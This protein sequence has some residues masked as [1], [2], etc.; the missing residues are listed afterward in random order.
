MRMV[1]VF[2]DPSYEA[3][4]NPIM[5]FRPSRYIQDGV[6]PVGEYV[7]VCKQYI[8]YSDLDYSPND[9]AQKIID[10]SNRTWAGIEERNIKVIPRVVI[11]Y[12][13]GP[14][15]G[16]AGYWP[17][18]VPHGDP[19]EQWKGEAFK[20]RITAFIKNLGAAWDNDPRVA[21]IEAGIWGNWGEHHIYPLKFP[22]GSDR[23]PLDFQKA[24]GDAFIQAFPNKKVMIRYPETFTAYDFGYYWDSFALPED[25]G[26]GEAI[27]MK[28]NWRRQMISGEV[29]YD[30]GDQSVVGGS[31][32]GTLS[33]TLATDHI[34]NWVKL[35]HASS[36]GWISDY[37]EK[38]PTV[39]ANASKMQKVLGYRFVVQRASYNQTVKPGAKLSL[40]FDVSNNGSAPFYYQWPVELSLLD[41]QRNPVWKETVHVDIRN[42]RP[43]HTYK[44]RDEFRIPVKLPVGTYTLA[45]AV[46]DPAGN[47]P[48]L[49]FANVNYYNGGRMP[50]GTIGIGRLPD[51]NDLDFFDSL[52]RD[53]SLHYK[54]GPVSSPV[55][56]RQIYQPENDPPPKLPGEEINSVQKPGNLA[57]LKPVTVSSIESAYA[58][59]P[60]KAVD[61]DPKTRW[62]SE[63]QMDPSWITVDLEAKTAISRVCLSWEWSYARE[64]EIQVSDDG[65]NWKTVY[66]TNEGRGNEEEILFPAAEARYVRVYCIQRALQWG[67]SLYEVE[68]YAQ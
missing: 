60:E 45:L 54:L 38:N 42:W 30:W 18:G 51:T 59:Y 9:S 64:Y 49:R 27:I 58:N 24:M 52:Y 32:N 29:A 55:K 66:H 17:L 14:D 7:T 21:A 4:P 36:L 10:W 37:D 6:F 28:D 68:I 67:Y 39:A 40:E 56:D 61:G 5:G 19:V 34:I 26:C 62:S 23:I 15:D 57:F 13:N 25:K 63:W 31:P 47:L 20:Q 48:S 65:E 41:G 43:G 8:K 11:V 53:H 46:L 44:V 33:S 16:S 22:D 12:P 2:L 50:L 35:T 1:S 3:F